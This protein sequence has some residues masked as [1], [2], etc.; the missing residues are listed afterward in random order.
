MK[1]RLYS[2][3]AALL[4]TVSMYADVA[5]NSSLFT[6]ATFRSY[7][8]SNYDKDHDGY[9]STAE[10]N[11]VTYM[12]LE[13]MGITSLEGIVYF[14]NL[15]LLDCNLN[16]LTRLDLSK[17]T[18]LTDVFCCD[19]QLTTVI[20]SPSHTALSR[21]Y[22]YNNKITSNGMTSLLS[23][24]PTV[25]SGEF[26]VLEHGSGDQNV[27]EPKHYL[28]ACQKGWIPKIYMAQHDVTI[29][30]PGI[31][32][33]KYFPDPRFNTCV[34]ILFDKDQNGNLS[35]DE[36]KAVTSMD[37]ASNNISDLT[38]IEYFFAL[39]TLDCSKNSLTQLIVSDNT[40]LQT[41]DCSGNQLTS[42]NLALNKRLTTLK[43]HENSIQGVHMTNMIKSLPTPSSSG[44]LYVFN[45]ISS[46]ERNQCTV[47][48]VAL[49]KSNKWNV[50]YYSSNNRWDAYAGM[51][52]GV[53]ITATT[54]PDANFRSYVSS[55]YDM[56]HDNWLVP[57][58]LTTIIMSVSN[59][60]I[61]DLTGIE[62]FTK[63]IGLDCTDNPLKS[64]D[65]SKNTE[66]TD[67]NCKNNSQLTKLDVSKCTALKELI[68][69]ECNLSS[70]LLP[71]CSTLTNIECGKNQLT[72]LDVSKCTGLSRL[73]CETNQIKSLNVSNCPSLYGLSVYN[74]QLTAIDVSKN[75]NLLYFYCHN[76]KLTTLDMSKNA[77]MMNLT[78]QG[79]GLTSL[80]VSNQAPYTSINCHANTLK[81]SAM[82]SFINSLP[83]VESAKLYMYYPSKED[84]QNVCTPTD[85]S[86]A[87]EKKWSVLYYNTSATAWEEY[88]GMTAI[89]MLRED[90]ADM[91]SYNL[92]GQRV[93]SD[94]KGIILRNGKKV[95]V[96]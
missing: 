6:D 47:D 14:P 31:D 67:I 29:T 70:L 77:K 69:S 23:S 33:S 53:G 8:S 55:T 94:Y 50:Y 81:G 73:V 76:N 36:I 85:V 95:L 15:T 42:L 17:N 25:S 32:I 20:L 79:N 75:A 21:L 45:P 38:G 12:V 2:F 63:I 37:V 1:Q 78:C 56:D 26:L 18:K 92:G 9:L 88:G 80:I 91:P 54:F 24:M 10:A 16:E 28:M 43:C 68:C 64:L 84:E 57:S 93:G 5:I 60:N 7:V 48:D 58:E 61:S 19:N 27:V 3:L 13:E 40:E 62:Y 35:Y 65:L 11:S 22:C 96:K 52:D 82:T 72:A 90:E 39:K 30:L 34:S 46:A 83:K 66:L 4:L 86:K 87:R 89:D 44:K 51:R 74:N 49:A 59:K 71:S 41:L